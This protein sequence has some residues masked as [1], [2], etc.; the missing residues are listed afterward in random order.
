MMQHSFK[1]NRHVTDENIKAETDNE[2]YL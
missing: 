2:T 1:R